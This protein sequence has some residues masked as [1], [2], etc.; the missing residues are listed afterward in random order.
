MSAA[1]VLPG[2][3]AFMG[4]EPVRVHL[5]GLEP[6]PGEGLEVRMTAKLRVQNPNDTGLDF[7]G[8]SV[9]LEVD[10]AT[11]AS[12]VSSEQGSVARYD[13]TVLAIPVSISAMT[14]LR[15]VLGMAE[16]RGSSVRYTLRG[17]LGLTGGGSA[18][19]SSSG[20]IDFPGSLG[21]TR[22]R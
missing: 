15:H 7:N 9:E 22:P 4:R 19:F 2:C 6:L 18:P 1:A 20:D 16:G 13:D 5:V 21:R 3:A 12:G 10:G 17:R 14:V 8:I 11:L